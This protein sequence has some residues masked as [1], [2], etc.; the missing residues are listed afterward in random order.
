MLPSN[1]KP[2][3][4]VPNLAKDE[5][6]AEEVFQIVLILTFLSAFI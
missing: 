2:I 6:A 4:L 3:L 5:E 1:D